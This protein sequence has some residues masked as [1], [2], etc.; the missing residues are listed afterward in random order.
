V[1]GGRGNVVGDHDDRFLDV[2]EKGTIEAPRCLFS[3]D[4]E[5]TIT[6]KS[7]ITCPSLDITSLDRIDISR[8]K[9]RSE[10]V[11]LAAAGADLSFTDSSIRGQDTV[12]AA[13]AGEV[14]DLTGSKFNKTPLDTSG[15]TVV[16]GP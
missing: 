15:C 11:V 16:I 1:R 9:V 2:I 14:C 3:I 12:G 6:E 10:D 13:L 5:V 7:Q 8:T 4:G